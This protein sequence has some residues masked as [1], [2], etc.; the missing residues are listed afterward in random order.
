MD[1]GEWF[2]KLHKIRSLLAESVLPA[3]EQARE[4][5]GDKDHKRSLKI[6][7]H[8]PYPDKRMTPAMAQWLKDGIMKSPDE[9]AEDVAKFKELRA[10][11]M[12]TRFV[13]PEQVTEKAKLKA[14]DQIQAKHYADIQDWNRKAQDLLGLATDT[15]AEGLEVVGKYNGYTMYKVAAKEDCQVPL[16][17]N[18]MKWCVIGSFFGDYGGPPYYPVVKEDT[19]EPVAM[20]IP[21]YFDT[22]PDQAVR[23][24]EN[25]NRLSAAMLKQIRPLVQKVLPV[26]KFKKKYIKGVHG[27]GKIGNVR[28]LNELLKAMRDYA[29]EYD[30]LPIDLKKKIEEWISYVELINLFKIGD[31]YGFDIITSI[32]GIEDKI[33]SNARYSFLYAKNVIGGPWPKGERA[34]AQNTEYAY[35]YTRQVTGRPFPDGEDAIAKDAKNSFFYAFH[36][37]KGPWL[38]GETAIAQ[39]S[40]YSYQYAVKVVKG[41][42]S[43]GE[44]AIAK[45]PVSS[46]HYASYVIKGPFPKGENTIAKSPEYAYRYAIDVIN[47]PFPKGENAIAKSAGYSFQYALDVIKGPWPKG[48]DVIANNSQYSYQYAVYVIKGPW[49]K[50]EDAIKKMAYYQGRYEFF[51]KHMRNRMAQKKENHASIITESQ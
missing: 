43:K 14:F 31:K 38:K 42:W 16:V 28:T 44:D 30:E 6:A 21:A 51:L 26:G 39:S 34:I 5:L 4:I 1:R 22:D 13:N 50:G 49:P 11:L 19:G 25:T 10:K 32:P 33:A 37:I 45:S 18:R 12:D 9:H 29:I 15:S 24:A 47:S 41:P 20:V 3:V 23:N 46:C 8:D 40:N 36:V 2:M 48:E 7:E 35:L 17:K 27:T